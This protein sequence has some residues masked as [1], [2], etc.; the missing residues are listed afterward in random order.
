M[1]LNASEVHFLWGSFDTSRI[2]VVINSDVDFQ[3]GGGGC[4]FHE[5][6]DELIRGKDDTFY[7]PV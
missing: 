4:F 7:S 5:F 2:V 3:A 1:R 6:F